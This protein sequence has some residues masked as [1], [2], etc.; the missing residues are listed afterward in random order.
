[1]YNI[2]INVVAL[3][4]VLRTALKIYVRFKKTTAGISKVTMPDNMSMAKYRDQMR[5]Y[6]IITYIMLANAFELYTINNVNR[7]Q[8]IH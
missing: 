8:I 4:A 1:M 6:V 7:K 2:L 3:F 5:H